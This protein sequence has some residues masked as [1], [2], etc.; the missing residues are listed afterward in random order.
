[1]KVGKNDL[2]ES[3][4][5]KLK[6]FLSDHFSRMIVRKIRNEFLTR[7]ECDFRVPIER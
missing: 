7:S 2:S 6:V 5:F 4:S 3:I 1:M